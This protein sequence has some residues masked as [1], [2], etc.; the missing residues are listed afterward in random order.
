MNSLLSYLNHVRAEQLMV[1]RD[2]QR[3]LGGGWA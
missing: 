2:S 3:G 1:P